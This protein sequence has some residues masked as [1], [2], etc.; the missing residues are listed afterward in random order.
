MTPTPPLAAHAVRGSAYI[1]AASLV[2]LALGLLRSIL[3]ARLL[4]PAHFGTVALA[5]FFIGLVSRLRGLGLDNAFL[6]QPQPDE[7]FL[8]TYFWLRLALDTV[9]FG[10]LILLAPILGRL[11]ADVPHFTPVLA[12]LAGVAFLSSVSI[13]QEM[14]LR[15]ELAFARLATVD[16][17]AATA[18]VIV[19]P[20]AAWQGWGVWALVAEQAAGAMTRFVFS[21]G[22]FRSW[23][24]GMGWRRSWATWLWRYGRS[25]WVIGNVSHVLDTFDDFWVGTALG[26]LALGYYNRAYTFARYTRRAVADPL[27]TVFTP[28]FARL[29]HDRPRL[30]RA[31]TRSASVILRTGFLVAGLAALMMSEF[32]RF[33]IG[34][35]WIPMLW[36]FR[37]LVVYASL[38][39]VVMLTQNLFFATGQPHVPRQATLVQAMFFVPAV[40]VATEVAGIAG[41][42]LVADAMLLLGLGIM[43]RSLVTTVDCSVGDLMGRPLVAMTAGFV[44]GLWVEHTWPVVWAQLLVKPALFVG[45]Y[46]G[47]LLALERE[48]YG[49][50]LH[51]LR[52]GAVAGRTDTQTD[53]GAKQ[54]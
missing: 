2:T 5:M 12:A 49:E 7:A 24:P 8:R 28:I 9:A 36:T 51:A 30:S 27:T 26:D 10:I 45:V 40:I 46:A 29:Q 48:A 21:W 11:Y 32:I 1:F 33:I 31:Y 44:T 15:R 13:F 39:P 17:A 47:L 50:M 16:V 23:W 37:L 22:A 6:H 35:K 41:A 18:M 43:Y 25:M 4:A 54:E 34:T 14:F 38:S 52:R 19:G 53:P 20:Y 3:L 42:A